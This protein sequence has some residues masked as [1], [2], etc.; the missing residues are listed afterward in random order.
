MEKRIRVEPSLQAIVTERD[1]T[2]KAGF[3][4]LSGEPLDGYDLEVHMPVG[5]NQD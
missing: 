3:P 1:R 5:P 2:G 4:S